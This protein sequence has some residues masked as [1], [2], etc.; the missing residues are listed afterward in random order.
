MKTSKAQNALGYDKPVFTQ[1]MKD[2]GELPPIGSLFSVDGN[3]MVA[4][5]YTSDKSFIVE[6]ENGDID[7]YLYEY[8]DPIQSTEGSLI[9]DIKQLIDDARGLDSKI[10]AV[11]LCEKYNITPKW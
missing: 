9:D 11:A 6:E 7:S 5:G 1:A 4:I 8:C 2:Y 3:E 10:L